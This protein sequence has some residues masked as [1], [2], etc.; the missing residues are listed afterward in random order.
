MRLSRYILLSALLVLG[1]CGSSETSVPEG[2]LPREE[3]VS[4]L[5]DMHLAEAAA[6][7]KTSGGAATNQFAK[8]QDEYIF[9]IH[10]TNKKQFDRSFSYYS[11]DPAVMN[12]MYKEIINELSKMQA[13]TQ[14]K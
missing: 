4:L 12:E 3:M 6:T 8:S 1:A 13:S 5:T 7:F 2:V 10:K 11:S 14:A 9:R